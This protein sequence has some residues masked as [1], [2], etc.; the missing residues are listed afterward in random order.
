MNRFRYSIRHFFISSE[1]NKKGIYDDVSRRSESIIGFVCFL[2][3]IIGY[4]IFVCYDHP[5]M[6]IYR[7]NLENIKT[8]EDQIKKNIKTFNEDSTYKELTKYYTDSLEIAIVAARPIKIS[9]K[10]GYCYDDKET[11]AKEN[12]DCVSACESSF[13]SRDALLTA[14]LSKCI[15]IRQ[16]NTTYCTGT[17]YDTTYS[18]DGIHTYIIPCSS[19]K[20]C[21]DQNVTRDRYIEYRA[22]TTAKGRIQ[23]IK[24]SIVIAVRSQYPVTSTE[25]RILQHG[26]KYDIEYMER[27]INDSKDLNYFFIVIIG[28]YLFLM[29]IRCIVLVCQRKWWD[30]LQFEASKKKFG[31]EEA[32][33]FDVVKDGVGNE[34]NGNAAMNEKKDIL[35]FEVARWA[36][37][38]GNGLSTSAVQ[39]HFGVGYSRAAK[40]VDQLYSMGLC[41]CSTGNSKPRAMLI[42]MDEL[43]QLESSG[44]F[45][46]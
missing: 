28:F 9:T 2:I 19:G 26:S 4:T 33:N 15:T 21:K 23:R 41:T 17:T 12:S 37:E 46:Q 22:D 29:S 34:E 20:W 44:A 11:V 6:N 16:Q 45:R 42:G 36:I 32:E 13:R 30:G 14:C 24:D 40:I 7:K 18:S 3:G 39:R 27:Q 10:K 5:L 43:M 8:S 38:Y 1:R 25:E 31:D 35:L